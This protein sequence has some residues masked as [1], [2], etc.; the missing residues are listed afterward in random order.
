[1]RK[2]GDLATSSAYWI[3]CALQAGVRLGVFTAIDNERLHLDEVAGK[4]ES[5]SRGTEYL[6]NALAAMDLLIK[7][8]S[9]YSNSQQAQELLSKNSKMYMG[10]IILH[11]HHILDGWAQLDLAVPLYRKDLMERMSS[12]RVSSWV[13][14]T[15]PWV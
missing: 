9:C 14:L 10:H 7:D 8:G 6:L 15:W 3:G 2:R 5:D 13:C 11:H 12:V 4:I 1:M